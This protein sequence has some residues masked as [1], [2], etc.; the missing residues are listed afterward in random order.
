MRHAPMC[1]S[2][3]KAPPYQMGIVVCRITPPAEDGHVRTP[4][5]W[6]YV[7]LD[8]KGELRLQMD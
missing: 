4:G 5:T 1:E 8:Q 3:L 6:E 7:T 2:S